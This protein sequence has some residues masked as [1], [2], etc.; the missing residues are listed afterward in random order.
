MKCVFSRTCGIALAAMLAL[1]GCFSEST[2]A[3]A[4]NQTAVPSIAALA[5]AQTS[6]PTPAA[7]TLNVREGV[8]Y[9]VISPP[10]P[11]QAPQGKVEVVEM[12]WYGCPHCYTLEPT[13]HRYLQSKPDNVVFQQVPS[14]LSPR[15]AYH[16]KLFYVGKML[17]PNGQKQVHNKI[18]EALQKQRRQINN[19]DAMIRFFGEQG[20]TAEQVTK[21][22][23]SM[24]MQA[25]LARSD[26]VGKGSKADSVPVIIVNGKYMTSPSKVG[27][28]DGL[29][30]VINH[31]TKLK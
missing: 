8:H 13:I 23:Q 4:V 27:S 15:W 2:Q 31:L 22:L 3:E 9:T 18:F 12:F 17:D 29:L 11:T 7:P 1:A 19:D 14:T 5:P 16:A 21:A 26:E 10:I 24:E 20:F 25:M 28:E 6:A 30:Q